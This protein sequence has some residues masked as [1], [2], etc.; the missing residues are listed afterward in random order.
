M[1]IKT[2]N[3][4]FQGK[5]I[6]VEEFVQFFIGVINAQLF[7][8]IEMEVFKPKNIQNAY[9]EKKQSFILIHES[10][11]RCRIMFKIFLFKVWIL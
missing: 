8:R 2:Y 7:K 9:R 10:A 1:K 3:F 6:M 4:L 11:T 5:N